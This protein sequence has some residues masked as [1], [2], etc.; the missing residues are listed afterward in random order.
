MTLTLITLVKALFSAGII[1]KTSL[2]LF[3]A[4]LHMALQHLQD[5]LDDPRREWSRSNVGVD[6]NCWK[7]LAV[8]LARYQDPVFDMC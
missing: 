8:R 4:T 7:Y 6:A 3:D 2:D 1:T 5:T